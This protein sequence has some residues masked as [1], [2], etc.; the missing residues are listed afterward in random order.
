M[1]RYAGIFLFS[2]ILFTHSISPLQINNHV[3]V[4]LAMV[5]ILVWRNDG[6]NS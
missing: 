1:Y 4:I 6:V 3:L 5:I 2:P